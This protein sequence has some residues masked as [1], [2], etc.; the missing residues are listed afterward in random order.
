[1]FID[2]DLFVMSY[3]LKLWFKVQFV[4][5]EKYNQE[6]LVNLVKNLQETACVEVRLHTQYFDKNWKIQRKID[7]VSE[8]DIPSIFVFMNDCGADSDNKQVMGIKTIS[9][10]DF[11]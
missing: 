1:M 4:E 11:I 8:M 6:N 10:Y 3:F 2:I 7:C 9:L 5:W